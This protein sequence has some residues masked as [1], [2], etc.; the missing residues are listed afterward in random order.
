MCGIAGWVASGPAAP[1]A[2]TL[3][4]MLGALAHRGPDG[5]GAVHTQCRATRHEVALG[6]RRLAIIDPVGAPQPMRATAA[7][8]TLVF[9]GEIYNFRDLRRTLEL[10]GLNCERDSDTEVLLRGYELWGHDVVH[11]LRGMFA[12]AVW[13]ERD[14]SLFLARDRFGEKPLFIAA[15]GDSL[16]FA[17]E[18]KAL[19]RVPGLDAGVDL[20]AVRSYF[21]YRYVPGPATLFAGIR[22]LPPATTLVWRRGVAEQRRYWT[23]PDRAARDGAARDDGR[24]PGVDAVGEFRRRLAEAVQLTMVSDVP[25][26]A[27]LSG[28]L[29][30]SVIVALM[31]RLGGKVKTFTAGFADGTSELPYAAAVAR[32]FGTDHREIVVSH[33]D[34]AARLESL[35]A[36]RDAPVSEPSDV[37]LHLL[38][39]AAACSVKMVLTGEGSDE[40][41][42]GYSKHVAER[43]APAVQW[44]PTSVRRLLEPLVRA[45][46]YRFRRIKTAAASLSVGDRRERYVRWFGAL[47]GTELT[48]LTALGAPRHD[49]NAPPFDA[50]PGASALRQALYFDQTSWLPDNLL[51]RADRMTM[52][53]SIEAR[54]PFLDHELAEFVSGL[55]DRWRVRGLT[56]KRILR[57][58]AAEFLPRAIIERRKVGFRVPVDE[59]FR[60]PLREYLLD[61]LRGGDSLTRGY[62]DGSALDA[63]VD[64]HLSGRQN[65]DK[66]L[67]MLLNLEIWY[68]QYA[69]RARAT[70]APSLQRVA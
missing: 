43:F 15:R 63:L 65:H 27:F 7:G 61:H 62:Y 8:L 38:A 57:A 54:V 37:A 12:F 29:D 22:K 70:A 34:V 35:V 9:N 45:L 13:D 5:A 33:A 10:A 42:G 17:S 3:A 11:R 50:E 28:G 25:F 67:W 53:A 2:D 64:E 47:D 16:F 40:L 66:L 58:A 6:H 48:R 14:E 59:W 31:S 4:D 41:L 55:P 26:G 32:E 46:P 60:G 1:P 21:A 44:L 18:I 20:D 69:P 23:A 56:G 30:S 19:L 39:T 24:R 68:R 36:K 52:A 49:W 51:E